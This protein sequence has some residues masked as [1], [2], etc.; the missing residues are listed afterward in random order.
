MQWFHYEV[1]FRWDQKS[2]DSMT[3]E[4]FFAHKKADICIFKTI[5]D[6]TE[7]Y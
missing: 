1:L 3:E 2:L 4:K 7:Y 6:D 5:M